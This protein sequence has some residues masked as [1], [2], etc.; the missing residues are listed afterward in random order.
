MLE[1]IGQ[2][3]RGLKAP[4]PYELRVPLLKKEVEETKAFLKT[5]RDCWEANGCSIMTDAWTIKEVHDGPFIFKLVSSCIDE[6]GEEN[7]VHVISD[8]ASA[9][10]AAAN[11]LRAERPNIFW[12][13]C[14]AHCI[15]LMLEDIGKF[16]QVKNTITKARMV[17]V[18]LY[19]HTIT[20]SM[21]RKF[22]QKKDLVR[23]GVTRFA[24]A[25]LSLQS[26]MLKRNELR[27]MFTS[28][29]WDECKWSKK[30]VGKRIQQIVLSNKFWNGVSL[31]LKLFEPLVY[32]LRRVDGDKVPSMG[33]VYGDLENAK[34]EIALHMDNDEK[35]YRPVWNIIDSRFN[36]KLK[37]PLHKAGYFLNPLFT[38]PEKMK[39]I[40]NASIMDGVLECLLKFY[41]ND[42]SKQ[43]KILEELPLYKTASGSFGREIAIRQR[44]KPNLNPAHWW[45][46]HGTDTP[47][48]RIMAMKILSLTCSSSGCERNWSTFEMIHTKKRNRL[49]QKRLNDLVFVKFNAR[50]RL[51]QADRNRDPIA[52]NDRDEDE[53]SES[54]WKAPTSI[55]A[56]NVT[57]QN[58]EVFPGE[59]LTWGQVGKATGAT[60]QARRNARRKATTQTQRAKT[61]TIDDVEFE[62]SESEGDEETNVKVLVSFAS[63]Q[64][65]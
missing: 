6:I 4:T 3:G 65:Q 19:G 1:A 64:M 50:L 25:F 60:S 2:Y 34:K 10:M 63:A 38:M 27:T 21:M 45:S 14:A 30:E 9:N 23:T 17:T 49:E 51:R 16:R 40:V 33:Y 18:F 32:V 7:V 26:I 8:N 5:H 53:V 47:F 59:G 52:L 57:P 39:L 35:K 13:P 36:D 48:L 28:K 62:S 12:T 56:S 44:Q 41:P 15:D 22:T 46:I 43:D 24:T 37:T 61:R 11:L 20:L 58:E 42:P 55:R 31:T 29:D 54:E